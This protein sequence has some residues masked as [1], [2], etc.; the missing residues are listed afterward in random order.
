[1]STTRDRHDR[2][3]PA[4]GYVGTALRSA[5]TTTP[6]LTS[7]LGAGTAALAALMSLAA[8]VQ[9]PCAGDPTQPCFAAAPM[10]MYAQPAPEPYPPMPDDMYL[11]TVVDSD[12]V[13]IG[14]DTYVWY[15]GSDGMRHR[16]FYAH[17]D[18][19]QNIFRRRAELHNT[20]MHNG[21]RPGDAR[22]GQE[23]GGFGAPGM[24]N[25]QNQ[26][27]GGPG[28]PG[29]QNQQHFGGPGAPGQQNQQHFGGPGV[30]GQQNQQHF[31]GPG[32][33]GQQNQHFGMMR[34][35]PGQSQPAQKGSYSDKEKKM[36]Q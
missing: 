14:G 29:Q 20:M 28:M 15:V 11:A 12:V 9:V 31:G 32:A 7:R 4:D 35:N 22:M 10:P 24:P 19:R 6:N 23:R 33:P 16:R 18:R 13:L 3:P 5:D 1:M 25:Q 36:P 27:F 34:P 30:P 2:R 8:C 21:G 26:R 17:G